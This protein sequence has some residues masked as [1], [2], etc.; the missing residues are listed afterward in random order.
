MSIEDYSHMV[1]ENKHMVD[2]DGGGDDG[3]EEAP[4]NPPLWS[5]DRDP[6]ASENKDRDATGT[7]DLIKIRPSKI[8]FFFYI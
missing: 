1:M 3:D 6:A 8:R 4:R 5:G 7:L 2:G